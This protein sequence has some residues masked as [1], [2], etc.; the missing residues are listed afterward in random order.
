MHQ[1][2]NSRVIIFQMT[3]FLS[4]ISPPRGRGFISWVCSQFSDGLTFIA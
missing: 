3:I 2:F 1:T 4:L